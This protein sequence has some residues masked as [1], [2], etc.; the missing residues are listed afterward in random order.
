MAIVF[1]VAA[2]AVA[3][4]VVSVVITAHAQQQLTPEGAAAML[5]CHNAARSLVARGQAVNR[6]GTRLP[7]GAMYALVS[8]SG[9]HEI[10]IPYLHMYR[11]SSNFLPPPI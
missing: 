9:G 10:H 8:G 2:A 3:I 5:D 6:D 1:A 7:A 4:I 11:I